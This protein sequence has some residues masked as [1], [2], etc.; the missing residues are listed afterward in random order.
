MA[1]AFGERRVLT[2]LE[3]GPSRILQKRHTFQTLRKNSG[4]SVDTRQILLFFLITCCVSQRKSEGEGVQA[5]FVSIRGLRSMRCMGSISEAIGEYVSG[6][7]EKQM[8]HGADVAR[9]ASD[10]VAGCSQCAN[11]CANCAKLSDMCAAPKRRE[12]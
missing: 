8:N 3:I 1:V 2:V 6:L 12:S 11:M 5:N 10:S 9:V 4:I 7:S